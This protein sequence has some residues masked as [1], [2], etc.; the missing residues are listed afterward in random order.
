MPPVRLLVLAAYPESVASTRL[1]ACGYFSLLQ[2][3]GIT[4]ELHPFLDDAAAR[5][6]Y[7]RGRT[8][9]KALGVLHGAMRRLVILCRS[10]RYDAV[11]VQREACL[12]GPPWV[13]QILVQGLRVPLIFD[14]DDALWLA[15]HERSR[16]PRM[17]RLLRFPAKTRTLLRIASQV[18][19]GSTYLAE[20]AGRLNARTTVL[21]TVVSR[22]AWR[23]LPGRL[24]GAWASRDGIPTI[25]WVG[26]HSTAHQLELVIPALTAL[27]QR[28]HRFR[29]RLVGADR[30]I[31]VP[32]IEVTSVPWTLER[33]VQDF[34]EA[35]IA[36]TPM[37]DDEW[38]QG[39]CG[40]KQLQ[41]MAVG[42]PLVGSAQGGAREFLEH[43]GNALVAED[44]PSTT[45][46]LERL[47]G[48]KP[49]R[50]RLA[51][52]GRNLVESRLCTEAQ[53]PA[54]AAIIR[55]VASTGA[56][57]RP[58]GAAPGA[59]RDD[60]LHPFEHP[61]PMCGRGPDVRRPPT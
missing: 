58:P 20:Y 5:V 55:D 24:S 27:A 60:S 40:L 29:V 45:V 14:F 15:S 41:Y 61:A 48:D 18:I 22:E 53:G 47:L 19:A 54:L 42:V 39:K 6:L 28:G 51:T 34:R 4:A 9:D 17:A 44:A 32:G 35:D 31:T 16:N 23:P 10:R 38:S 52:V 21:R 36:V 11:F 46:A 50:A 25:G 37:F 56:R 43:E 8:P 2:G 49:L 1:R 3:A 13:E 12:I 26:S 30:C 57:R 33:E 59:E 7:T